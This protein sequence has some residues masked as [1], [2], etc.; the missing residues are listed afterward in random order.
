MNRPLLTLAVLAIGCILPPP[1]ASAQIEEVRIAVN[2]LTCSLCAA[3]LERSLRKLDDVSSVEI[4]LADETAIVR[5]KSGNSFDPGK[6][7]AA[8]KSAGQEARGFEV[9]L[10]AVV[11]AENGRYRLQPRR[12]IPLVRAASSADK[13]KPFVDKTVRARA[14]VLSS[15]QSP[16]ELEVTDV[17]AR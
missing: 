8:V 14:K 13:L 7:R 11:H 1:D 9:R 5:L 4:A 17:S 2:G 10:S 16:V 6:F 15:S 3:G 12:G